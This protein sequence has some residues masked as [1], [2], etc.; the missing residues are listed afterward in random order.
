MT[1]LEELAQEVR[2]RRVGELV[3]A[4]NEKEAPPLGQRERLDLD[5]RE[6]LELRIESA[7]DPVG[8]ENRKRMPGLWR[9][10]VAAVTRACARSAFATI[11]QAT[12]S[13]SPAPVVVAPARSMPRIYRRP[14]ARGTAGP[15]LD[16]SIPVPLP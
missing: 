13:E 4:V 1:A 6:R 7:V 11:V 14:R 3:R 5:E 16:G 12:D 15:A 2:R 9:R 8:E 10:K